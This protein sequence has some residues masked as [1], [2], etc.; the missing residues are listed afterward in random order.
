MYPPAT[1]ILYMDLTDRN[2]A[3]GEFRVK[4]LTTFEFLADQPG[5]QLFGHMF[6]GALDMA[7]AESA[8]FSGDVDHAGLETIVSGEQFSVHLH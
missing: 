3:R 4:A 7:F 5:Q 2:Q 1:A 8:N 6:D